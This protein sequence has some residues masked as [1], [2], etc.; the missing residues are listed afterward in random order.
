[1][2]MKLKL[3]SAA[4][5]LMLASA[6]SSA[7]IFTTSVSGSGSDGAVSASATL[8][9]TDGQII[10]TLTNTLSNTVFRSPG[11]GLSDFSFTLNGQPGTF[12]LGTSHAAGQFGTL[13]AGN[14]VTFATGDFRGPMPPP[15]ASTTYATPQRWLGGGSPPCGNG[16]FTVDN[17][18]DTVLLE[19]IGGGQPSEMIAPAIG[20]G[21]TYTNGN[22][23]LGNFNAWVI[24]PGTFTLE[25]SGVT[26]NTIVT[27]ATFSFGTTP[28]T[29]LPGSHPLP[30]G[31]TP[32][33]NS[34]A[35]LGFAGLLL[36]FIAR[37]RQV[38]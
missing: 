30:E 11:Q 38:S 5:T 16:T 27:A 8:N 29:F 33:P 36:G 31:E 20:N 35:L 34:L 6:S 21:G 10:V 2:K 32:E 12:N 14:V 28:D 25:L 13:S 15:C 24:G 4:I 17:T 1:M 3:C 26:A 9:V 22:G 18:L 19:T 37:R 7:T 23:G